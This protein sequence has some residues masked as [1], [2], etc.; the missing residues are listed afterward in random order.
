M[1]GK[2]SFCLKIVITRLKRDFYAVSTFSAWYPDKPGHRR[3]RYTG[4]FRK[5][6]PLEGRQPGGF[7]EI[8]C[9]KS[10]TKI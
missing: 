2:P 9:G 10:Y 4:T 3:S 1:Q 7:S 5:M 8:S 6:W